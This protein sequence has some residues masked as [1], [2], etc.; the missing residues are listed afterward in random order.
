MK[1][2]VTMNNKQLAQAILDLLQGKENIVSVTNCITRMRVTVKDRTNIDIEE[3]KQ[4][5]GVMGVVDD[6]AIQIVLGPGKV[7]KVTNEFTDIIGLES[8]SEEEFDLAD[9]TKSSH[10]QKQ[11]TPLH[12]LLKHIGNIFVPLIPGLVASGLIL[13]IANI[14]ENLAAPEA[15]VLD[16]SILET[17]LFLLLSAIGNLLFGSLGVFVGINTAREFRGT[18]VLGGIAGLIINAPVLSDIGSLSIFGLDLQVSTGLGGLLGVIIA[19]YIFAKI[20][21]FVRKRTP[22]SLDLLVT[23]LI[24]ILVGAFVTLFV[25]QPIAGLVMSGLTWFLVD[26]ML[27]LGGVFGGFVLSATFLP[28][29]TL[30]LHQGLV[31]LHLDLIGNFGSTMLLPILAMAGGGQV[32]AAFAIYLKTKDNRLKKTVSNA[33]P[34]GILGIGEPLIYGVVLPLGRPF[35]TA[36][37]G[38]GFGGAFLSLQSIGAI[39]VGPSGLALIPLIA[40]GNYLIYIVGLLI[41]YIGGFVLTYFFGFK[42]EM[43][44]RDRKSVV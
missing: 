39:T 15:G 36:C 9:A 34:V 26:I 37:L 28:L 1:A 10:K 38:A 31:P 33:L 17:D 18:L 35:I 8:N 23:P 19:A 42:D 21:H 43:V 32:G 41:S 14:I 25:I 6:E 22:D 29:V 20:E 4:L 2:G 12:R 30:G 27:Q 44:S 3:I 24:T 40:D 16:P 5:D 11:T 7:T 13:G